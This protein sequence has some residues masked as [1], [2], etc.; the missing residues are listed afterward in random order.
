M[1]P[2]LK[3]GFGL[4]SMV[5]GI[6]GIIGYQRYNDFEKKPISPWLGMSP[7]G[8]F[9]K[10][11]SYLPKKKSKVFFDIKADE[12]P[13]GKIVI[14]LRTDVVPL[15]AENF[16]RLITQLKGY[17]YKGSVFH[18]IIPHLGCYGGDYIAGDGTESKSYYGAKFEDENFELKHDRAGVLSMV[19]NGPG[20]N[21]SQFLITT[22]PRPDLDNKQVVFGS[23]VKG[24]DVLEKLE[25]L[26]SLSGEV[27][28]KVVIEDC[29]MVS[30]CNEIGDEV[31][32]W[33]RNTGL[34]LLV[35]VCCSLAIRFT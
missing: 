19:N 7:R 4:L 9:R 16:R 32:I 30:E 35:L 34:Y 18:S 11:D 22:A 1:N 5:G 2:N 8:L 10:N 28:K 31:N 26:G 15:T 6:G 23:V 13:L 25:T 27:S 17:G 21:G 3:V 12:E 33:G 29:Q 20:S 14:E 24:M